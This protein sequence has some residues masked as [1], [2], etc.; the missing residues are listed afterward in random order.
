[1]LLGATVIAL[2]L[3]VGG[4]AAYAY[5]TSSGSGTGAATT[6]TLGPVTLQAVTGGPNNALVPGGTADVLLD[7]K[8]TNAYAVT[9]V[10]VDLTSGGTITADAGHSGCTVT[11]VTLTN[12]DGLSDNLPANATT[13]IHLSGAASMSTASSSG[14]QGATFSIPVTITVHK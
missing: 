7:V 4:G 2:A 11:G 6:G 10:D 8:N 1:L 14:C 13:A 9:L 3:G 12:Q 5:F